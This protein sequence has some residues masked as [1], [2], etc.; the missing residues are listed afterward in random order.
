MQPGIFTRVMKI[1]QRQDATTTQAK[2]RCFV[3]I[4]AIALA[5][6]CL[7]CFGMERAIGKPWRCLGSP[8]I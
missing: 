2:L 4:G 1:D 3:V 7:G 5:W 6:H 8:I